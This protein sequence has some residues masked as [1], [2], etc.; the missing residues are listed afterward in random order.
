MKKFV[1]VLFLLFPVAAEAQTL[2]INPTRAEFNASVDHNATENETALVTNYEL[3]VFAAG[4]TVPVRV[5][6]LAK[7]TPDANNLITADI[8]TLVRSLPVGDYFATV[9][10]KGPGGESISSPS[11]PFQ[12]TVRAPVAPT[13]LRVTK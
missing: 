5:L 9:A 7:P 13:N 10:A 8:V 2:V 11:N 3:R 12:V 1:F 4:G 6:N